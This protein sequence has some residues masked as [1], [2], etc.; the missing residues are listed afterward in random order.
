MQVCVFYKGSFNSVLTSQDSTITLEPGYYE[1]GSI[2]TNITDL[3]GTITYT[4]HQCSN[5][6]SDLTYVDNLTSAAGASPVS[7]I[8][9]N[10][11]NVATAKGG[12]YTT[13]YYKYTY[14]STITYTYQ[15]ED[16]CKTSGCYCTGGWDA[17]TYTCAGGWN[18]ENATKSCTYK[19]VTGTKTE[20][21]TA[22]GTEAEMA[23]NKGTAITTYYLKSCGYSNG[24]VLS[25]T[26]TY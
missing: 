18:C 7:E 6:A 24:Q 3:P 26:I 25:A 19:T 4:H 10:G 14:T 8:T 11:R 21:K 23:A 13:P 15:V 17:S 1:G 9:I 12:C 22:Y 16:E 20:T 2:S 5:T